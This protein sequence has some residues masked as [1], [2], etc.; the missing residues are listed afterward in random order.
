MYKPKN[1]LIFIYLALLAL[2]Y[3]ITKTGL[4]LG[5]LLFFF[6]SYSVLWTL[7]MLIKVAIKNNSLDYSNLIEIYF[8]K[9]QT[10]FYQVMNLSSNLGTIIIYQQISIHY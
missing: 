10:F 5:F 3:S 4:V 6:A 1:I 8:G 9:N 7:R 2:P